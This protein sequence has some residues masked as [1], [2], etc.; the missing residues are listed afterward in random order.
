MNSQIKYSRTFTPVT[1]QTCGNRVS[2]LSPIAFRLPPACKE[3][4]AALPAP[5]VPQCGFAAAPSPHAASH[6]FPGV[7]APA[8]VLPNVPCCMANAASPY[9]V[10]SVSQLT[11][12]VALFHPPSAPGAPSQLLVLHL[13]PEPNVAAARPTAARLPLQPVLHP[14][15]LAAEASGPPLLPFQVAPAASVS[16]NVLQQWHLQQQEQAVAQLLNLP[17]A[18]QG[19]SIPASAPSAAPSAAAPVAA[20]VAVPSPQATASTTGP[21]NSNVPEKVAGVCYNPSDGTWSAQWKDGEG[22]RRKKC[23]TARH[24]GI[25]KAR[26]LAVNW[27]RVNHKN[28]KLG[29]AD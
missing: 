11:G 4:G 15:Q 6:F 28:K 16:P 17:R 8:H 5:A 29:S 25:A 20:P 2:P 10:I 21:P 18:T 1:P 12:P 26:Q 14:L 7:A 24:Y 19:P 23:F 13:A 27:R 9:Q 22:K 3:E